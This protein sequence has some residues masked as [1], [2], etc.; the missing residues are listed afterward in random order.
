MNIISGQNSCKFRNI[1][2]GYEFRVS[3]RFTRALM[4][5]SRPARRYCLSASDMNIF[6]EGSSGRLS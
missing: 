1:I 6:R 4:K 3:L 2:S 5:D